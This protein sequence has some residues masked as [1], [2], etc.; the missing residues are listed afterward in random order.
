M[1]IAN[2]LHRRKFEVA[3][4]SRLPGVSSPTKSSAP[5]AQ[6]VEE[7][8]TLPTEEVDAGKEIEVDIVA[9]L[10]A[11]HAAWIEKG[12]VAIHQTPDPNVASNPQV[13]A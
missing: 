10:V 13:A 4:V 7:W 5:D 12:T 2:D 6:F 8:L 9:R 3:F 11:L 1:V